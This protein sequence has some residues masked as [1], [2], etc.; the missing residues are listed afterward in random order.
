MRPA[1]F[2]DRDGTL[3]A[4][5]GYPRDPRQVAPLPGVAAALARLARLGFALVIV[6]NQSGV[7]RGLFSRAE[8]DAVHA[9]VV[10]RFARAG[11]CFDGAY[12]CY[13]APDEGCRCRKP[14]PGLLLR[15]AAEL[16]LDPRRSFMVGDKQIDVEAGAAAGCLG[17][18]FGA[19]GIDWPEVVRV[20][21]KRLAAAL[22]AALPTRRPEGGR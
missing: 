21:E 7:G 19:G 10:R 4:D 9:E 17:L 6:S 3:I 22:G 2:L 16:G 12:Y 8:A 15:A 1:V 11:V 18:R 5:V 13:H 20:I 14:A